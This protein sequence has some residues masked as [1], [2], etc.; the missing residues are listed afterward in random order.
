MATNDPDDPDDIPVVTG[1][2]VVMERFDPATG[3]TVW[4][5][6]LGPALAVILDTGTDGQAV[7]DRVRGRS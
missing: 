6:D 3:A 4:Q 7:A 5:A 1:L 2:T